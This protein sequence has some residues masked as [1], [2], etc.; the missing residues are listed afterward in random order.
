[1]MFIFGKY[2]L[3][4]YEEK[5]YTIHVKYLFFK[6]NKIKSIY[7]L[8]KHVRNEMTQSRKKNPINDYILR[9]KLQQNVKEGEKLWMTSK[10]SEKLQGR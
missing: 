5:K 9:V 1:M 3:N 2:F 6:T 7:K 8:K 10:E 4:Q